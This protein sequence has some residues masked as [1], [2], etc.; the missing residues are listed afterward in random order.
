METTVGLHEEQI[1]FNFLILLEFAV[2]FIML[3]LLTL[4]LVAC[5]MQFSAFGPQSRLRRY[6][7][8]E[9]TDA[10]GG[11]EMAYSIRPLFLWLCRIQRLILGALQR[12]RKEEHC[13]PLVVLSSPPIRAARRDEPTK[14][15]VDP[16]LFRCCRWLLLNE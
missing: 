13:V 8:A 14:W 9:F 6:F 16:S 2:A 12:P 11:L 4:L 5:L 3:F 10:A 7:R 15:E 1:V